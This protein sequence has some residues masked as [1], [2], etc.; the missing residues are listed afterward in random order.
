[1][2]YKDALKAALSDEA[3]DGE[4]HCETCTCNEKADSTE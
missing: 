3:E 1:M 2:D 4:K